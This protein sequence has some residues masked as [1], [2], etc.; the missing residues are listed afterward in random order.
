MARTE[1][2]EVGN[3]AIS[4]GEHED[5]YGTEGEGLIIETFDGEAMVIEGSRENIRSLLE[6]A[7]EDL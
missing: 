6:Q 4:Y 1:W 3:T 5:Q 2:S 7:L